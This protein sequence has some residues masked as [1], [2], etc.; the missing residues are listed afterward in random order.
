MSY[1]CKVCDCAEKVAFCDRVQCG[2]LSDYTNDIYTIIGCELER[3]K[4]IVSTESSTGLIG[5]PTV[6]L[7]E[8]AP[9]W[10]LTDL[11]HTHPDS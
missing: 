6:T 3:E 8:S 11:E 5:L 2:K 9:S 10:S 4:D 7:V 1:I